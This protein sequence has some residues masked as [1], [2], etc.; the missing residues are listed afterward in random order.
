M[1]NTEV[2][3]SRMLERF[4]KSEGKP[5]QPQQPAPPIYSET[6]ILSKIVVTPTASG[7]LVDMRC[8]DAGR[9]ANIDWDKIRAVMPPA[10]GATKEPTPP[11]VPDGFVLVSKESLKNLRDIIL[12]AKT[13]MIRYRVGR[14]R[15]MQ[16]DAICRTRASLLLADQIVA[17]MIYPGVYPTGGVSPLDRIE[18]A[19][20]AVSG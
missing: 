10:E 2:A 3:M 12:D 18:P 9:L 4:L 20:D 17:G 6:G 14:E 15:E 13:P 19:T 16:E 8:G 7:L 11:A 1:V 5:L